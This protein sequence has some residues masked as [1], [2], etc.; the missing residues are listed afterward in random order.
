MIS[1]LKTLIICL[2]IVAVLKIIVAPRKEDETDA[3]SNNE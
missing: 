1:V 2:T 3:K